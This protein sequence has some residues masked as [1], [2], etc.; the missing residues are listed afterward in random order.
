VEYTASFFQGRL[1]HLLKAASERSTERSRRRLVIRAGRQSSTPPPSLAERTAAL[2]RQVQNL[3]LEF[4]RASSRPP[5]VAIAIVNGRSVWAPA[6]DWKRVC[7][8]MQSA[9]PDPGALAYLRRTLGVG[10]DFV[11]LGAGVG[12]Y[13]LAAAEMPGDGVVHACESDP[14]AFHWLMQNVSGAERIRA[15]P[16]ALPDALETGGRPIGLVRVGGSAPVG[17]VLVATA[18]LFQHSRCRIIVEYCQ[19][20]HGGVAVVEGLLAEGSALGLRALRIGPDGA[21]TEFSLDEISRAF[22]LNLV[23][24]RSA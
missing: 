10:A 2:S 21:T 18:G 1:E 3:A 22:S 7:H 12:A 16:V 6:E 13:A 19:A 11:D 24:E 4:G 20:L 15:Y 17:H 9:A 23:W 5:R 8:Y 14:E